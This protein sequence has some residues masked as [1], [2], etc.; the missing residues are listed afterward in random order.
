MY[1]NSVKTK[2]ACYIKNNHIYTIHKIYI[3]TIL[4]FKIIFDIIYIIFTYI[5]KK[6]PVYVSIII[7]TYNG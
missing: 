4:Y 7:Y 3:H 2:N 5:C 1:I 6:T